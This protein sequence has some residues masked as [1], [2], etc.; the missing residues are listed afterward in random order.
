MDI[1]LRD[2]KDGLQLTRELKG[3]PDYKNVPIFIVTAQ[4]TTKDRNAS[5][6]AGAEMFLTKPLDG[7]YLLECISK[8]LDRESNYLNTN[9]TK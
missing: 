7:K 8:A 9:N 6:E 3:R 2:S 4:N 5:R 1:F